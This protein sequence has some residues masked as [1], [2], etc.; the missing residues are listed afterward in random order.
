MIVDV[1][2]TQAMMYY[3]GDWFWCVLWIASIVVI[4]FS[5]TL[6]NRLSLVCWAAFS[7]MLLYNPISLK[8]ICKMVEP[9]TYYRFFWIAPAGIIISCALISVMGR[10]R[11]AGFSAF[12]AAAFFVMLRHGS[13]SFYNLD[14]FRAPQNEYQLENDIFQLQEAIAS[15]GKAA[16]EQ[17]NSQ[18]KR[19]GHQRIAM[20]QAVQMEYRTYDAS[21][22]AAIRKKTY[23]GMGN[24][25]YEYKG[26][27]RLKQAE[28]ILGGLLNAQKTYSPDEV[29][30]ALAIT[31]SEYVISPREGEI[32]RTLSE[33]GCREL[34]TTDSY[35]FYSVN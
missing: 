33:A 34:A 5:F 15:C 35:V 4:L 3:V 2:V 14:S 19:A 16:P 24:K 8:L 6:T 9:L 1:T 26:K 17:N 20:P 13:V 21:V 11:F 29:K 25:K 23:Q 18:E 27:G 10:V 22:E 31:R 32:Y 30:T 28:Y 7:V 12:I